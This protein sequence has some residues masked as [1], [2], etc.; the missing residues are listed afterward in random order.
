MRR[1]IENKKRISLIISI[2]VVVLLF[3]SLT[4]T[5][6]VTLITLILF[7]VLPLSFYFLS[8][9]RTPFNKSEMPA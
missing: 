2:F 9:S 6:L 8:P 1:V 3:C 4:N 5:D 7:I